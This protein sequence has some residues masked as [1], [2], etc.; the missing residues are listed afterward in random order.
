MVLV[1]PLVFRAP[2]GPVAHLISGL[3]AAPPDL[4]PPRGQARVLK[5]GQ[6]P[7]LRINVARN[8]PSSISNVEFTSLELQRFETVFK[9]DRV[10]LR[11]TYV[12]LGP[13]RRPLAPQPCPLASSGPSGA[14]HTGGA[15]GAVR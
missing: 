11:A 6:D 12:W 9:T 15:Y 3:L 1:A 5:P 14:L 13:C 2:E 7:S 4:R 8:S 10:K